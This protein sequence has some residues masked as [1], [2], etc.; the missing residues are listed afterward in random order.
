MNRES[1]ISLE[2]ERNLVRE[3]RLQIQKTNN[4]ENVL[5]LNECSDLG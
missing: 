4:R 5:G 3:L 2:S 1:M